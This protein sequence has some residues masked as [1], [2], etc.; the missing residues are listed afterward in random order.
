[1]ASFKNLQDLMTKFAD[2][3]ACR[4]FL[5]Q[6]RWGG[7]PVCPY[8]GCNRSY[9]IEN[10]K[11]FK[12]ANNKC[13]KKYSVTVGTVAEDTNISLRV[14]FAAV[15]LLS[16][17]KKGISSIQLGKDVGIAQKTAW[18][19]LH[20]IREALREDGSLWMKKDSEADEAFIGGAN[21]N[22]HADKKHYDEIGKEIDIKATVMG[23][24]DSDSVVITQAVDGPTKKN[25]ENFVRS[26]VE[27]WTTLIT[28]ASPIYSKVGEKYKHV[29]INHSKGIYQFE[30]YTTN[31][32]ENYWSI[33]KRG[34]YGIYHQV[35]PKHLQRYCDE[36]AYRFNSR[37]M[38][39]SDRFELILGRL[40][41]RLTYAELTANELPDGKEAPQ[42]TGE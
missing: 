12:C 14:W 41:G 29:V 30:G 15:Y 5:V 23:I 39:D 40:T 37:K 31:K 10:G 24:I 9:R 13:H 6:H 17:H 22:R 1:M 7:K 33:L 16:A 27:P 35:S 8:C 36:F 26:H 28:D 18:F 34:I 19:V 21:K 32:I 2:E 11:R 4:E 25:A 38:K 3:Q 20:R 42:E